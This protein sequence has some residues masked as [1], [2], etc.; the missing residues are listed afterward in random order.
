MKSLDDYIVKPLGERYN[1]SKKVGDV[2][3]ILN[4]EIQNYQY[5][6]KQALVIETPVNENLGI[7][8]GDIVLINHNVFRRWYNVRA[9][10]KNSRSYFKE[11]EYFVKSD[12]I[13]LFK[14]NNKWMPIDKYCFVQPIKNQNSLS[15]EKE[16]PLVGIIK[17]SN[18]FKENDLVGF[19]PG[20]EYEFVFD[21]KRL[22][23]VIEQFITIKYEYQG[24]EEAYNPSWT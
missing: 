21:N 16:Q 10:E 11:D 1:N 17:Y 14:R 8:K 3:L 24:N 13:Y 5:I 6:N 9:E 2:D 19:M 18:K 7:K 23:R 4:T 20:S 12:Q 22:Y 15:I